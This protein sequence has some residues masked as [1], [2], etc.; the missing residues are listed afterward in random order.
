MANSNAD[1]G[2][3]VAMLDEGGP[4]R[5]REKFLGLTVTVVEEDRKEKIVVCRI[6]STRAYLSNV[7][8]PEPGGIV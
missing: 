4:N 5:S 6:K 7:D 2:C 1:E 3:D 8:F